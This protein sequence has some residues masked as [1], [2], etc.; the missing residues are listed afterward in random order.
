MGGDAETQ[1]TKV[2]PAHLSAVSL[3][4]CMTWLR[5]VITEIDKNVFRLWRSTHRE[6][7]SHLWYWSGLVDQLV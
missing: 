7:T 1:G 4:P 2:M 3:G 5:C 6:A